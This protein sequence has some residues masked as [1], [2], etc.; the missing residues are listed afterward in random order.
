MSDMQSQ[1]NLFFVRQEMVAESPPPVRV[2]GVWPWM[3]A[4]LFGSVFDTI[5]TIV[6]VVLGLLIIVPLAQWGI[7]GAIWDAPTRDT[8]AANPDVACWAFV[9]AN[10]G[11]FIYGRY[12]D[13]ERWRV[14]VFF[15]LMALTVIPLAI[16]SAPFKRFNLIA[17]I[18]IF[19]LVSSFL[20]V[21]G[22]LG[23]PEVDTQVWGGLFLTLVVSYVG[24]AA[25]LPFGILLALGRR[26]KMPIVHYLCVAIIEICRGIPLITVLFMAGI[27]L[28]LFLP[29]G[30][31]FDKLLRALFGVSLFAS[32][33][34]AEVVR[35]G[36]QAV[37]KGQYEGAKSLGLN[38]W[39]MTR[40][41][42]LPQAITIVIPG[43]VNTFIGLF[44]D[45]SLVYIIAIFELLST[46]RNSFTDPNW[47]TP[48]TP[49]SGL[50]FAALV[51]W[52]FCFT[53]S[54]YSKFTEDRLR[55]GY[56]R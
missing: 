9:K 20:L 13:P 56:K 48:S 5:L 41:I 15:L 54:R 28:P 25:S 10:M 17:A 29:T 33:Y 42:I 40:L 21:G 55:V 19:P 14:N 38:Y 3:R 36:L 18:I 37:P 12:P 26:S 16:P 44:K 30:V 32:C 35:G 43:I 1:D 52:V 49:A 39:T 53:M 51:F 2:R 46:V 27:L 50:T 24:M 45:T 47:S 22:V 11:Q 8:C 4:N 7:F 31:N 23:L 34:M 6:G